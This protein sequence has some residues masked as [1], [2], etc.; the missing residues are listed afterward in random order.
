MNDQGQAIPHRIFYSSW[1]FQQALSAMTFVLEECDFDAKYSRVQ[2]R[3]FRCFETTAIV[4][5]SRPFKVGRGRKALDLTAI[6][7][8]FSEDEE[9][10]KSKV[11]WLRDKI[12]S[13]SD[14]E[15]MEYRSSSF[16][17]F[18]DSGIRMPVVTFRESLYLERA[19]YRAFESLLR[20][21]L[22][23]IAQYKFDFAQANPEL[24]EQLKLSTD[25]D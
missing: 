8:E 2:L 5:F 3:K 10:L 25:Q 22:Y 9:R 4:S 13:H 6:G 14:E 21:L 7:F 18:D 1:D 11:L 20:R 24:F 12:V 16:E 19:E 23:A 15:E 17:A